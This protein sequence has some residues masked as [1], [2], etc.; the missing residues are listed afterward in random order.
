MIGERVFCVAAPCTA[1]STARGTCGRLHELKLARSIT[2][3]LF[4][5]SLVRTMSV[6]SVSAMRRHSECRQCTTSV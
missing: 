4:P 3:R 6:W 1:C 5:L 2:W